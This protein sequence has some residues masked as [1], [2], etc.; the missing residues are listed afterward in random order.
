MNVK[1][2]NSRIINVLISYF[3]EIFEDATFNLKKFKS[4]KNLV[5][6]IEF[7]EKIVGFPKEIVVK[8]FRTQNA[9]KEKSIL[10]KLEQEGILVPKI[11][12]YKKRCM[13]LENIEGENLCDFINDQLA[14]VNDLKKVTDYI[15]DRIV[16]SIKKLSLWLANLH[17]K[18]IL[19]SSTMEKAIVL[20]KGDTRLRDFILSAVND[21]IY[22]LDFEDCYEGNHIDDLAWVCCA[23][24]DTNPGIFEIKDLELA[25]LTLKIDLINIFLKEYYKSNSTF[26]FD[27]HYFA[28]KLIENLNIVIERRDAFGIIDSTKILKSLGRKL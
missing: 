6:K 2:S 26:K 3:P 20:N 9:D 27:F 11:L 22:G 25:P 4:K 8:F 23:L 21:E 10:E 13:I 28:E 1:E 16:F 24:L 5:Y 12:F 18:N 19:T 17:K 15:R 14:E 7:T